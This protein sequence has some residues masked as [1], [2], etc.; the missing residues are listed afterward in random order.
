MSP[1][2]WRQQNKEEALGYKT[3]FLSRYLLLHYDGV[4]WKGI[5]I[6]NPDYPQ[7]THTTDEHKFAIHA[8]K[9]LVR[10]SKQIRDGL[11]GAYV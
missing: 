5:Y 9:D 11:W 1:Y 2:W 3:I 7:E 10:I 4:N 6:P 8:L